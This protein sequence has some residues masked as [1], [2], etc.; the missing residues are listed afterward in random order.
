MAQTT[1]LETN[2]ENKRYFYWIFQDVDETA[3]INQLKL[4]TINWFL[5]HAHVNTFNPSKCLSLL[6]L[7]PFPTWNSNPLRQIGKFNIERSLFQYH[8]SD[9]CQSSCQKTCANKLEKHLFFNVHAIKGEIL[10]RNGEKTLNPCP[11]NG[12]FMI[13]S[14]V[15]DPF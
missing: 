11:D 6:I 9:V 1:A 3:Y 13:R 10:V 2:I 4:P 12:F 15:T 7:I 14:Q 8:F 5:G